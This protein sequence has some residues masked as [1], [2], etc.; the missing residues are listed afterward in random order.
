MSHGEEQADAAE[1][2]Y[3]ASDTQG[4]QL[5]RFRE[6]VREI[7]GFAWDVR[8][9]RILEEIRRLKAQDRR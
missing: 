5:S 8:D 3:R 2:A 7:L 1:V 4:M 9:E 6:R